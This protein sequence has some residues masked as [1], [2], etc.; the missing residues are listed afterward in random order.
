[1]RR[2]VPVSTAWWWSA[3]GRIWNR[4]RVVW[5]KDHFSLIFR[6]QWQFHTKWPPKWPF[7]C[8]WRLFAFWSSK[9][10]FGFLFDWLFFHTL[11]VKNQEQRQKKGWD[12]VTYLKEAKPSKLWIWKVREYFAMETRAKK[13]LEYGWWT[14]KEIGAEDAAELSEMLTVNTTL[15]E[16]DLS[17]EEEIKEQIRWIKSIFQ[18]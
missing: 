13:C 4:K 12:L 14:G 5:E 15:T 1:M 3:E 9:K 17:G 6:A 10:V 18:Y 7:F 2:H 8:D 16:L 11:Q